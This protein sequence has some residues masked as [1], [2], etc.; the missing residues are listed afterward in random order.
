MAARGTL[1]YIIRLTTRPR[2]A[3]FSSFPTPTTKLF[4]NN[5]FLESRT[6][7]WIDLRN[8]A[9]NKVISKVP[10]S[11]TAEMEAA[12]AAAK[13]AFPAWSR[14]TILS[15]QQIMFRLHELISK[16]LAR[17]TEVV[18][19][20]SGKTRS[21]AE[22][23][24]L[25]CLEIVKHCCSIPSLHLGESFQNIS[26][27]MDIFTFRLPLG[28]TAGITPFNFP[29]LIPLMIF[30]LSTVCGNTFVLKTSSYDPGAVMILVELCRESGFPPGVV[31]VIHGR[32]E[33]V[34]FLCDHPDIKAI[35]FVGSDQAGNYIYERACKNGKRA[36]C[37]LGAKN[38]VVV[39]PDANKERTLSSL[40]SGAYGGAGQRCMSVSTAIFVG[41]SKEWI[42]ELVEKA[43]QFKVNGGTDPEADI[44]PLISPEAKKRVCG[45]LQS[46]V[47]AGAKLLLDGR[48]I[49]VKGYEKGN[50]VGPTIL[51]HVHPKMECYTAEIFGPVLTVLEVDTL[52]DAINIVR[53][54]PYGNSTAIFTTNG[55]SARKYTMECDVGQVGVNVAVPFPNPTFSFTGSRGSFKGDL[56]FKGKQ[57]LQ[58][59]TQTKTVIQMWRAEH[60]VSAQPATSMPV[61]Q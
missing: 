25:R 9:T 58:F 53:T 28:V 31:N 14:S 30:A 22:R 16:N 27:D 51:S 5:E 61:H 1:R 46:G 23:E 54:N 60:S 37:N 57:G 49:K 38:Y 41:E 7:Q 40:L 17:L 44:G 11:T 45:L 34:T 20:E 39:M 19:Q 35:S 33:P 32:K 56:H 42:S 24:S 50:F 8:P 6:N 52:D 26:Q 12:V 18:I 2:V 4:I 3:R 15:R 21:D 29:A 59:C 10:E 48:H 47:D 13:E 36:Q 55:A 43:K